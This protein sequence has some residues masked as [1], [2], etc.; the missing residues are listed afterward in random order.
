MAMRP[1]SSPKC[2]KIHRGDFPKNVTQSVQMK[3]QLLD[4]KSS[5][6]AAKEKEPGKSIIQRK[7]SMNSA[8]SMRSFS[9]WKKI[10]RTNSD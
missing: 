4:I 7:Y 5:V 3:K 10:P 9:V 2:G 8:I 6:D 1:W